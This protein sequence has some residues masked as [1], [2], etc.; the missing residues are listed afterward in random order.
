MQIFYQYLEYGKLQREKVVR[1]DISGDKRLISRKSPIY[2][3]IEMLESARSLG[4]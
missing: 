4:L 2:S 3:E 1:R